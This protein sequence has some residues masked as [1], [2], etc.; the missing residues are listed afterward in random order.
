MVVHPS[1]T[2]G[3]DIMDSL[4]NLKR[5]F[6]VILFTDKTWEER[7]MA[8][9]AYNLALDFKVRWLDEVQGDIALFDHDLDVYHDELI[10]RGLCR[11]PIYSD[12]DSEF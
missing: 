2:V 6:P 8:M 9:H 4:R 7:F 3:D 1:Q 10:Y 11:G 5:S 12:S